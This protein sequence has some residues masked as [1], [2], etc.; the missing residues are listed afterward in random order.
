LSTIKKLD[1]TIRHNQTQRAN[2]LRHPKLPTE[3]DKRVKAIVLLAELSLIQKSS[4]LRGE[5]KHM[6]FYRGAVQLKGLYA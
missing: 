6:L 4:R 1:P 3:T 5:I 2:M